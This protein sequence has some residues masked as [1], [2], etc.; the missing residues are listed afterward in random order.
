MRVVESIMHTT[1][2]SRKVEMRKQAY[3]PNVV[4]PLDVLVGRADGYVPYYDRLSCLKCRLVRR[5]K[6]DVLA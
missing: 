3:G 2:K 4:D 5:C 6:S 1:C